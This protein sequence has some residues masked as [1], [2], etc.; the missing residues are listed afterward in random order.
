MQLLFSTSRQTLWK[1][2][3]KYK[4]IFS[5]YNLRYYNQFWSNSKH[6]NVLNSNTTLLQTRH[7]YSR[8][9]FSFARRVKIGND[10]LIAL[11]VKINLYPAN[12]TLQQIKLINQKTLTVKLTCFIFINRFVS[13]HH[14]HKQTRAILTCLLHT[15]VLIYLCV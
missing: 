3:Q 7:F 8:N 14:I 12:K 4:I 9:H 10:N 5:W 1:N 13:F 2:Y 6:A 15:N 11:N